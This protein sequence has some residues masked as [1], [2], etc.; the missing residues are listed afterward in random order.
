MQDDEEYRYRVQGF[1]PLLGLS[2]PSEVPADIAAYLRTCGVDLVP[3]PSEQVFMQVQVRN[4][5][6]FE[7]ETCPLCL[8]SQRP[9]ADVGPMCIAGVQGWRRYPGQWIHAG[10]SRRSAS[11][12]V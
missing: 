3:G 2:S 1:K 7:F 5:Y 6:L 8:V 11:P 10:P 9:R 12:H 4:R